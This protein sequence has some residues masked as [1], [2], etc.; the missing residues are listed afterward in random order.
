MIAH[1]RRQNFIFF[2]GAT[3]FRHEAL[4]AE[5]GLFPGMRWHADWLLEFVLALRHGVYYVPQEL[6]RIRMVAGT[7]SDGRHDWTEQGPLLTELVAVLRQ[8]YPD[9]APKFRQAALL[10]TYDPAMLSALLTNPA[11]RF[12][13]TPLLAW[14]LLSYNFLQSTSSLMPRSW[15]QRLRPWLRV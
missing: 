8:R 7:Y 1:V 12:Y 14:R 10:P 11:S 2:T 9:L 13:L 6:A 4:R 15:G 3:L 5:G